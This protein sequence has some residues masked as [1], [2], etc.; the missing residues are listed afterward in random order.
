MQDCIFCKIA[1]KE[2][3]AQLIYEDE[4]VVAFPDISPVAPSHILIVP[5][6]H[7][8]SILELSADSPL[9]AGLMR[10]IPLVAAKMGLSESGFRAVINTKED[11][12]Q[13]V[14]H[15][16]VHLL[17]GRAMKWPPG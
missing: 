16:H 11:G 17:G 6:Q 1:A 5:K 9:P 7:V 10:A 4:H 3:S 8:P 13:T 14:P 2:I 12:G 15:L